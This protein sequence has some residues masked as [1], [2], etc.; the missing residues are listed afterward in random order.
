MTK[1]EKPVVTG[2]AQS[3]LPETPTKEP[4]T[5][6]K[7]PETVAMERDAPALDGGPVT[8]DVH[9]NEVNSWYAFGW[10]LAGK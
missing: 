10:R 5:S 7:E 4:E 3:L 8:A 9:P 6:L 2:Q 1:S